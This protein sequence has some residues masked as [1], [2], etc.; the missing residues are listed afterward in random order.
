MT[1]ADLTTPEERTIERD[2]YIN[3]FVHAVRQVNRS[4]IGDH[5]G[6]RQVWFMY[7]QRY[8]E[9]KSVVDEFR[10]WVEA[11]EHSEGTIKTVAKLLRIKVVCEGVYED[12]E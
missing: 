7:I 12:M 1:V 6:E 11:E 3:Q 8:V 5:Y 2:Y 10:T 4:V 9:D